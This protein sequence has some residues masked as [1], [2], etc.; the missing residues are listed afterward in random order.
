MFLCVTDAKLAGENYDCGVAR[1]VWGFDSRGTN[2]A[3]VTGSSQH[4]RVTFPQKGYSQHVL[5][6]PI[7]FLPTIIYLRLTLEVLEGNKSL[8]L[9]A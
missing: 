1:R 2:P 5:Q 6:T 9:L 7:Y 8:R 3:F 4:F